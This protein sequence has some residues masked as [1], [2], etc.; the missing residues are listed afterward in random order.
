MG[1]AVF[2]QVLVTSTLMTRSKYI[3]HKTFNLQRISLFSTAKW[4]KH[5]FE[6]L[7]TGPYVM[8]ATCKSKGT[9][10]FLL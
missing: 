2:K 3:F 1:I 10:I 5:S 6:K 7:I 4:L 8:N 9:L